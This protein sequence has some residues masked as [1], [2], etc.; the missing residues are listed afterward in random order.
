MSLPSS[1]HPFLVAELARS[2]EEAVVM[3]GWWWIRKDRQRRRIAVLSCNIKLQPCV[4]SA[5]SPLERSISVGGYLPLRLLAACGEGGLVM[6]V[7]SM[8]DHLGSLSDIP[9]ALL[10][11]Q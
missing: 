9:V 10:C 5:V 4:I 3:V 1:H 8:M 11:C 7:W 6:I 2:I